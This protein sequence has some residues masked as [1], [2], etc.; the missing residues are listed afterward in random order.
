MQLSEF[1]AQKAGIKLETIF[2]YFLLQQ[3]KWLYLKSILPLY[4]TIYSS[5][6]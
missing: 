2:F 6:M 4:K 1:K 5:L 3:Y